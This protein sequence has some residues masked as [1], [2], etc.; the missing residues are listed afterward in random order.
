MIVIIQVSVYTSSA[1]MSSVSTAGILRCVSTDADF[2]CD[3]PTVLGD[4]IKGTPR[5]TYVE[6]HKV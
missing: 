2:L 6:S 4:M 5:V 3:K 1:N